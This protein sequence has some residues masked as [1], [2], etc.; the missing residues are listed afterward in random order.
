MASKRTAVVAGCATCGPDGAAVNRQLSVS[1][2]LWTRS[3]GMGTGN[4]VLGL[5]FG[6]EVPLQKIQAALAK[7]QAKYP[8]LGAR[9]LNPSKGKPEFHIC[10]PPLPVCTEVCDLAATLRAAAT[11]GGPAGGPAAELQRLVEAELSMPIKRSPAGALDV[12]QAR[13]YPHDD[14]TLVALKMHGAAM[15]RAALI[16]VSKFLLLALDAEVGGASLPASAEVILPLPEAMEDLL[17]SSLKS[18]GFLARAIDTVSY[19]ANAKKALLPFEPGCANHAKNVFRTEFIDLCF[20]CEESAQILEACSSHG[21]TLFGAE[22]AATLKGVATL[23]HTSASKVEEYG[24]TSIINCREFLEPPLAPDSVGLYDSGLP[25]GE[26]VAA[27]TPFWDVAR[28]VSDACADSVTKS[29]HFT[30]MAVLSSLF[31]EALKHPSFTPESSLRTSLMSGFTGGPQDATWPATTNLALTESVG[32]YAST[33]GI[34]SCIVV[35]DILQD[36]VLHVSLL[37]A[38]P[39]FSRATMSKLVGLVRENLLKACSE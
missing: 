25:L 1:E 36:G 9:I 21:A 31:N 18:K 7:A 23:K 24:I 35:I 19:V 33:H 34:G 6:R 22:C 20:G 27:N 16:T 32:P 17:P 8:L 3:Y 37:Y 5:A 13:I 15:D 39:L 38:A 30:E 28:H 10:S 29:H 14:S 2:E 11:A 4:V 12:F 26:K